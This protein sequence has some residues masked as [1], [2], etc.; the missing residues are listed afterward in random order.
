MVPGG[1][2]KLA[3]TCL[4]PCHVR[5]LVDPTPSARTRPLAAR[6]RLGNNSQEPWPPGRCCQAPV[7]EDR[8]TATLGPVLAAVQETWP[9]SPTASSASLARLGSS[10]GILP[11]PYGENGFLLEVTP[12]MERVFQTPA[13]RCQPQGKLG[14][15]WHPLANTRAGARPSPPPHGGG[16]SSE[17]LCMV[18]QRKAPELSVEAAPE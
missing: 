5:G 15:N 16:T 1:S 12:W 14:Q 4:A 6:W 13:Q 3:R 7:Q 10:P 18:G 8:S 9:S 11:Q 17:R 2:T